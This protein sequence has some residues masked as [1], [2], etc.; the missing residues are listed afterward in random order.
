MTDKGCSGV[1]Q[2]TGRHISAWGLS[3]LP[4]GGRRWAAWEI[5]AE[6]CNNCLKISLD[7]GA[8]DLCAVTGVEWEV[9]GGLGYIP[10]R[11]SPPHSCQGWH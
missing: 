4:E 10:G 7:V 8:R 6:S 9:V 1:P 3:V 5:R 2:C 11:M